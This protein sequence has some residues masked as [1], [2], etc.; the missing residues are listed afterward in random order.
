MVKLRQTFGA[1]AG[2][3]REF[4]QDVI[5]FGRQPAND[6]AFDPHAD[7]DASGNH[8]E[9]RREAGQWILVDLGSRNGTL[10]GG[11]AIQRH[12][13][14]DGDE[15][16]FG[17]GGPRVRVEL[18]EPPRRGAPTAP[19]TPLD[20]GAG[21]SASPAPEWS[22]SPSSRPAP[23]QEPSRSAPPILSPAPQL[24]PPHGSS[25][26]K[27]YGQRTM[28]VAVAASRSSPTAG[29]S[30]EEVARAV[31]ARTRPLTYAL[32]G[33]SVV[34]L[35]VVCILGAMVLFLLTRG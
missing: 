16:E 7:L 34:L 23:L 21:P 2:R 24:T 26:P 9:L 35:G 4:N 22:R 18:D 29:A 19:P 31:E 13:V 17:T 14:K 12:V 32:V 25:S 3:T 30:A 10:V 1:H 20:L 5:R 6:F 15:V 28:D 8:A 11:R 27:L 33:L